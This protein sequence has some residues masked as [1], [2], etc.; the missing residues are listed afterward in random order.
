[1]DRDEL[2]NE[3]YEFFKRWKEDPANEG[4]TW[5]T[6]EVLADFAIESYEA[7]RRAERC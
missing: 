1:M 6:R 2:M 4:E 7:G 3:A 5:G